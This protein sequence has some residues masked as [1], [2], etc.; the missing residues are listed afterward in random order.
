MVVGWNNDAAPTNVENDEKYDGAN[1][2]DLVV[3]QRKTNPFQNSI[4]TQV[5][6]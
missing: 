6:I 2:S 5:V 1:S 3:D 4:S